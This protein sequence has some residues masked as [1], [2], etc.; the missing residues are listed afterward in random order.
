MSVEFKT[1]MG[2]TIPREAVPI[3]LFKDGTHWCAVRPDF[4]NLHESIAGFGV[5]QGEAVMNLESNEAIAPRTVV[6]P[7]GSA[8]GEI[9]PVEDTGLFGGV[10]P[11][12]ATDITLEQQAVLD[13]ILPEPPN[14]AY[15]TTVRIVTSMGSLAL[16]YDGPV[17]FQHGVTD[18]DEGEL[19][20]ILQPGR[21]EFVVITR[22]YAPDVEAEEKPDAEGWYNLQTQSKMPE[23]RVAVQ[24]KGHLGDD[25]VGV[26]YWSHKMGD[27]MCSGDPTH[28]RPIPPEKV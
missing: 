14:P 3:F 17:R 15:R 18:A 24:V 8:L 11:E 27:W 13:A 22:P 21:H 23:P 12:G 2:T 20:A 25:T 7:D 5:T 16:D 10:I 26:T 19:R 6:Q 28:W 9:P 1:L 4:I